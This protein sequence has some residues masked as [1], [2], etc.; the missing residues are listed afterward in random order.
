MKEINDNISF[1]EIINDTFKNIK[2][3]QVVSGKIIDIND[4]GEI[5]VDIGYKA[6]GLITKKEFSLDES[7]NPKDL[8]KPGDIIKAEIIKLNDG[9]GNVLL[10]YRR[11]HD[12]E[13]KEKVISE[14]NSDN[15]LEGIV[16]FADKNGLLVNYKGV[17][18]VFIPM[19]LSNIKKDEDVASYKGQSIKFKIIEHDENLKKVIGSIKEI[20]E[21][22]KKKHDE[23][24]WNN[25]EVGKKYKGIVAGISSYGAFV[26]IDGI[27]GLL[28]I[29]DMSWGRNKNPKDILKNG[30]EIEVSIKELDKENKRFK[31]AYTKKGPDPW[32]KVE[33]KYH[34]GDVITGKVSKIT[35]FGAFIELEECIEGL[36]HI[37]QIC[38][39]KINAA[40]EVLSVGKKVN[41]KIIDINTKDKKIELSIKDLEGTSKEYIEE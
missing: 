8:F 38:E 1:E 6:D 12:K 21:S 20:A 11:I 41:C 33:E 23:E 37:S 3:K 16:S 24:F 4:K 34:V 2:L 15:V 13:V 22:E 36:V 40:D 10:S 18:R 28:H 25:I 32:K 29:S 9:L 17:V 19:S 26:D 27:Q 7:V 35:P 31:L 5:F 30:E 39:K 14:I